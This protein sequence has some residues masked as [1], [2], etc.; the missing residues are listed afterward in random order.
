MI[1]QSLTFLLY[2]VNYSGLYL[3]RHDRLVVKALRASP[4][5][6]LL[7]PLHFCKAGH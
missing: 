3:C 4:H 1:T 2:P 7:L 6:T 5:F